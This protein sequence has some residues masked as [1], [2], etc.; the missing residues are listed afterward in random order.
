MNEVTIEEIKQAVE[1]FDIALFN[2][3]ECSLCGT[4]I[5]YTF[6][7]DEGP[8]FHSNC[9]C[10]PHYTPPEPRTWE[11]VADLFNRQTPEVRQKLWTKFTGLPN[12]S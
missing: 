9:D 1:H 11:S 2:L 10:T 12:P 7:E 5:G 3:R 6:V 8:M 4:S